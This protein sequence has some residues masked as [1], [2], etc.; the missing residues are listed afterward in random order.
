MPF[1]NQEL[2]YSMSH[3]Q[4]VISEETVSFHFG[5]HQNGYASKLEELISDTPFQS[6]DLISIIK[7]TYKVSNNIAIYNNASQLW[8][9]IFY[10]GGLKSDTDD[11]SIPEGAF[12]QLVV[13]TFGN[14]N[15]MKTELISSATSLFG[16]GWTWLAF[17]KRQ[18]NLKIVNTSNADNPLVMDLVPLFTIDVWEHAY[19]IDYRNRRKDY[20]EALVN[21]LVDWNTVQARYISSLE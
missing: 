7:K 19:Y 18:Q 3:L 2:P 16:S 13:A 21:T 10:W 1:T 11:N 5:K 6:M 8:N 12:K 14:E 17:D 9:H 4:P 15:N 20:V